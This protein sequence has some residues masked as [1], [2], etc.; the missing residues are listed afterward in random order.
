ML[1]IAVK[2]PQ[3]TPYYTITKLRPLFGK[4]YPLAE[5]LKW[6]IVDGS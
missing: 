3:E 5:L 1:G 6:S 2:S 4:K